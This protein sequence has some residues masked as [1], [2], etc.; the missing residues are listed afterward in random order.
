RPAGDE[1]GRRRSASGAR[2]HGEGAERRGPRRD[3]DTRPRKFEGDDRRRTARFDAAPGD[4]P[5]ARGRAPER[6]E[7]RDHGEFRASRPPRRDGEARPP[8]RD[9]EGR[10]P[11]RDGDARPHAAGKRP[12]AAREERPRKFEGEGRDRTTRSSAASGESAPRSRGRFGERRDDRGGGE[13]RSARPP[14]DGGEARA[15][16]P[17]KRPHAA[18]GEGRGKFE[19]DDRGKRKFDGG[20]ARAAARPRGPRP[21]FDAKKPGGGPRKPGG[22]PR[23]PRAPR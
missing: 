15:R 13:F 10:P 9:G 4:A 21:A 17:S 5:R 14:R 2:P 19:R 1:G 6:R 12:Y 3:A 22:A 18:P 16:A 23:K 20:D 8:R 11:R 7:E